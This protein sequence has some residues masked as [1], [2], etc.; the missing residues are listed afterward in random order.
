M[1]VQSRE[2]VSE[3]L[4]RLQ[5]DNESLQGKHSL[6][7]SLQQAEDSILPDTAEVTT[8]TSSNSCIDVSVPFRAAQLFV[9]VIPLCGNGR[10]IFHSI[11]SQCLQQL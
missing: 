8:R 2:Q 11:H 4:V 1:L 3:E 10:Q 9:Y 7:V 5:K 6:H